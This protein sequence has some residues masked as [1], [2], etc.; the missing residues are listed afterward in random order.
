MFLIFLDLLVYFRKCVVKSN[1]WQKHIPPEYFQLVNGERASYSAPKFARMQER[2]RSQILED[3]VS[4]L[5]N[6]AETGQIP[7]PYRYFMS[8]L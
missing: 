5:Q 1:S 4:N 2:T 7:K 3:L 6:H 8:E